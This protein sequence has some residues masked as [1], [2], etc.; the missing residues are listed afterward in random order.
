MRS[1]ARD[2]DRRSGPGRAAATL[3]ILSAIAFGGCGSSHRREHVRA[4]VPAALLA[5]ARPV[6]RG[7]RFRPGVAGPIVGAC[8][9][10]FGARYPAHVEVFAANRVVIV[11]AGIGVRPP[12]SRVEGRIAGA[13]C[14]GAIATLEP[15]GVVL[16]RSGAGPPHLSDLFRAWGRPLSAHRLLSFSTPRGRPVAVFV[17]GRRW[18]GPP[19]RVTL[20]SHAEVVL[21]V[22][23]H[24]PPHRTY[25]F[26][27]T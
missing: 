24:V 1:H 22:G 8:R 11:P 5:E 27:P 26:P 23:P 13:R 21:E 14:F 18:R 16:V 7:P 15:T 12:I 9:A 3:L 25:L 2:P 19:G 20:T 6:G 17:G 4:G 10:R